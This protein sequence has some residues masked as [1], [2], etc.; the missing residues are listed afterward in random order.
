MYQNVIEQ[1]HRVY[2]K[3]VKNSTEQYTIRIVQNSTEEKKSK[4]EYRR[5]YRSVQ[6]SIEE[7]RR[8]Q[9]SKAS[10]KSD[11]HDTLIQ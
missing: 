8:V 3:E 7:Y 1:N 10:Y 5:V 4:G 2:A 6:K 11:K 9:N